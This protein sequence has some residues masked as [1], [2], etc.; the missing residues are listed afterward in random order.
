MVESYLFTEERKKIIIEAIRRGHPPETAASLAGVSRPTILKWLAKGEKELGEVEEEAFGDFYRFMLAYQKAEAEAVDD[1]LC[2][3]RK[4]DRGWVSSAWVL[5]RR[6]PRLFGRKAIEL[7]AS[8]KP[9]KFIFCRPEPEKVK[10]DSL[11]DDED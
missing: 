9:M 5:E 11:T 3:V 10:S 7:E 2:D 8:D 4:G 6:F 1:L